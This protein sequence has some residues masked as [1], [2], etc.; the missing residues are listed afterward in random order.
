[1]RLTQG[2]KARTLQGVVEAD[3]TH[4][5]R[6]SKGQRVQWRKPCHRGGSAAE[7]RLSDDQEPARVVRD[8]SGVTADFILERADKAYTVAA[9]GSDADA[10]H[11]RQGQ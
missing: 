8:R 11:E 3:E 1:M 5:L 6:S 4:I 7:R 2:V 9:L 10:R